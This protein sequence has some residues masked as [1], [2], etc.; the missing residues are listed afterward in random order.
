MAKVEL[1]R[2]RLFSPEGSREPVRVRGGRAGQ[3]RRGDA[4]PSGRRQRQRLL[5]LAARE[6]MRA[7]LAQV[8]AIL[9]A[10]APPR[11]RSDRD[12]PRSRCRLAGGAPLALAP[13]L[14]TTAR[15]PGRAGAGVTPAAATGTGEPAP[16]NP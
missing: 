15:P 3:P 4:V 10:G 2:P 5:R 9:M 13:G 16:V 11:E 12:L 6:A 8:E 14:G 1:R 7:H